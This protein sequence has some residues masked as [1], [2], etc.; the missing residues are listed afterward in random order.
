MLRLCMNAIFK[1]IWNISLNVWV[2]VGEFA[3]GKQKSK[4]TCAIPPSQHTSAVINKFSFP[5]LG[6]LAIAIIGVLG[7]QNAYAIDA[8]G[9][10]D[11]G[12]SC[13]TVSTDAELRSALT[14][15]TATTILM[16]NDIT[17]ASNIS[18]NQ[19]TSNRK[20][21]VID[22]GGFKL[23]TG[24]AQFIFTNQT[25]V[26]W[27]GAAGS[28]TLSNLAELNSATG[29]DNTVFSMDGGNSAINIIVNNIGTMTN[30]MLAVLGGM[31]SGGA[32]NLNSQLVLGNF[33]DPLSLTFGTN[34]QLAQASNIKFTGHFDLTATTG[35]Y[36]AV[37]W[38]NAA[39]ANSRMYFSSTANVSITTPLFASGPGAYGNY[40]YTLEDGAQFALNSD[41]NV[42][43]SVNG[44]LLIGTYSAGVFG[45]G[46]VLQ[47][48][49]TAGT[50]YST[51]N[52]ITNGGNINA[53]GN[54][55][56]Q[57][58]DVIYNLAAGSKLAVSGAN[59]IGILATKTGPT[60]SGG[61]YISSGAA[62]NA[63]GIGISASHGGS[64]PIVLENKNSGVITA[65]TG[66]SAT[67]TG[68]GSTDVTN[69]GVITAATGMSV[70]NTGTGTANVINDGTINST[71]AGIAIASGVGTSTVD[72][73]RGSINA[74]AGTA[75]NIAN[76][77]LLNLLG[78]NITT[79]N[80][81]TGLNFIGSSGSHTLTDL[82]FNLNGTGSAFAKAAGVNLELRHVIFNTANGTVLNDLSGLT[83]AS[84]TEGRNT[85]NVSGTGTGIAATNTALSALD[86]EALDINVSGAGVG[87]N[88]TG[89]G[90]LDFTDSNLTIT[91]T[92]TEGTALQI[93]DGSGETTIGAD[94]QID[95]TAATAINFLGSSSKTLNNKGTIKGSVI[96]AGVADHIIN[97]N[98][99]L[100]GTLTTGA[101]NDT[102]VLDSSSQ[103]NDVINLGDGNNSVTIQNGAT[104]SSIITGNGN[105]TFTINGMSVGS[106]TYLGSLDAG[107]GLNTLNFNA[108]TDELAAATSLQGFTNINLVDSHI[109]LV[110]DDN[111]GSG[112]VNID[113]SSEL[114]FGSTF[115]GI[116]HATLGTGTGSAIVNN[117]A[118]VSLEQASMFAGTWQVNQGGALTASN[119][120]QL[121]SAK[122]GVDGT[123]NLDNI[124]LFNH[125]LTGNGTLNVAKN[126]A[127]TAF[128]FGST[129]GGAFSGI[130]N[131]T[132]TTFALSADNAAALASATLKLSDD[133]VTTVGTT[134][135][136]LHGLDLSGGTL[137][138]DGAVPQSQTSGVVTV[139][140]LAL[141]SG[142]VNITG[143]GS[144]DNTD[145]L[146][147]NVS[148]LEQDR[149]GSTLE[150][151]NATNV[152][153]DIDALDLLVNGT[154]ITSGT[155]GVQSAIQQGGSTVA[156][157]IH[158][159]GLASSN[160]NGDSGLYVNY[161]LSA[162]ELLA[163]GADALLLAT[164][165]GLTANR[166]LNAELFGVGGLVVDA[167]NGALTLAN[168]SNRYE[169]TT[170]VTA[171]ELIL[172][173]N[174]AFGQTSLLNIAS[175][176]SANINGYRQTVGA[177]TNTGT[178]TLGSGGV[179]TSG[180]LTNGGGLDLT[181]GTLN[182]TAGGASTVAGGLT[183]AGT[184]NI[185][186]GNLSVSA[187]N[188]GLSG[189]THIADVASVTLTDTGTLGTSTVEVLGTL[190]LNGA[191]AA[192]TN[193]LSGGG[194]INTN[195]AVTLSGNNSFS[196]AHQI[197]TDGELTVGQASNLG[198]S[199]ATVNLGTLTSHL[200]LNG[201]SESIANVLSGVAGSTVDI[202]GGADTA[203]TANNSGFLGQY[204]LAG[205]SKL[206]VA[207]TN[208]LG[209]SSS[210][211]LA[212]AGD[213][214]SL[215]G[216]NGTF[217]NSVTGSGVLQVTDD[218]EVTLTSSNG[219][220]NAV[221]I[222]IADAT[223]N[224][225]DIALF[226]HAL[227]GNGLLNVAKNDA[228]T[229]FDFGSTVG[230]AF[231]GIVNLTNTTFALS[232]DNA[233]AL[234][235][236]TLKLS[237]DS[238]TTV[239]TTDRTLHGLDL[240]GG[241]LIFDGSPP[242]SQANGVVTVTDLALNSGTVSIT[243]VG[244]WENESPVTSPNVSIL[245]QDRAGTTLE[246]INATNV[247][248]DVDALGLMI[249]GTAITAD[250][251]GVQSAIQQGGSTVA[252]AIHNYGLASSNSNGDS[253][254]YVNYTLSALELLADG[255][256]ALLLATESGLTANRVLNAELFGV[257]G[258]VVDAQNGAL[259]L[260]N[261]SNRYEGTTTVTA[262]ELILGANG[263]F[264]QTS[265]L[266]IASGASANING[267]RQTVG[268]VT[269][270]GTVTLGSGGVLTS[271]LLTNGGGLDLTGGT[272]NLTAGGAST[273]AGGLTGAGTLNING[274]NL[275]VS[276]T[277][278]GLS[279]QTHIADVASVTL[280]DTGTLGT[281][282]VEVLGTLN[283]NGANAAMTN[284]LSGGG[285][286]NTN[287]AVTLSG[288]N[289]FS[290][291]HQIGTDGELTVG[292]ASNLGASSATVNL[293]TLT[294]HLILNGVSE[295]IANVLSGVAGS[296]VDIIGGADTALTAN[297]SGFLGQYALAGNSKLTVASTN[298]LGAS[299]SVALAGAGDT[300]SLSGFNGTFGNS[301]TG[302]GV[303]QVTDDAEVTLTSSNGVSNAVTIDIADATLNLDD[304]ALFNHALTGNGLL[305]VAKNDASTA[306]DFGSTVGG[307]FS[308]IVN[309]TNTT[310]AL[311]ADNAAALARA[312]LK[313][314]DD[315]VTTVGTT[316][317]TLHG[318]DLNGGTLIFDGS[319][320]QSQA[321]G[322]VTV[323]DLALNSGTVSITGV[324]NWENESPVTSPNVSILEQDRAGTTLELINA[325][326]VTGDVDALGLMINGTAITADSQGVQSAIQQ[327]GST[328][329]N[330]IHNYGLASSN[331][332]GD[333]GLYVNYTLSALELLAD[334]A[335]ALLLA[336][337][338][339]L[340]ANRVLNAELF[341]VGGL[342]VDA[343]NGALTLANGNNRYEGTTTVTA[344]E[345]ILGANG[346]FGQTSLLDIASGAS[347]N[348]NGYR[349]T[350]GAVTNT[351]TVTLGSGG[352]L[353][354][355]L[356]TNGGGLDLT[357]GTL[358]LTA[359]GSST[360]AGGL[361]GA[362]TLNINGGNLAVSAAN[363][364][365]SGQTHIADVASVTLTGTGT[366]GTSAV[367]VLG[368]LNLNGANA[369]MTNVLSGGG[370]INTNAAV[371][372]SG[373]NSFSGAHQIGT[374][375][376]LTVG[377]A[378]NL[379]ASSATV[380]LGTLTSH[381]ILNGVSESIANVLSGV[382][383]STVD[384]IGGADTAL[385][386]NNS[387]FL[388]QYAL[389]GNSKLTVASTN[390]L[391]ASS[392]VALAGAG[393]TLSL[394]GFNGTF[395]NSV[396]GSG[397]LQVT[398][399]AEVTLT[400]SNGVG[401]A[402]TIDIA[403][404]TLNLNDIALFDHV[405]TGNGTLNVAKNLA[406]TAF[407]FGSTVGG[408]FSGIVNLTNTTFAL[409]ADNAAALARATLKLSDDSV[410][411]V[412]TTD[413]T[414]HGL[415]L[416]GGTLIFDGSPPQS[417][418]NGVVTVTD[419]ALNSGT[420]SITGAGNWENE[421]PV[422]PPN[423]SLLEQDRGDILLQLIDA[424]NVTGNANDL[425]LVVDGTA[426]TSG[427]QGVQSA[428]QQG[429]STVANAIH[430]YG[431][432][433]S[434]SNGD[435]GLYVNYTLS[436][437]ELLADGANALL[438]A[439]ESGL[440]ANRVLNAELFGVGGLVV[441][442]QNGALT[443][444][445]GNNRYEGTTTVN[446][447]ELIL[448][449]D[450]AFGQTSLL[451]I[452]NGASANI[453]GYRQTVGAVT[454]SGAVTLGNGGELTSTDTLI[455]T[456]M[457]NVTDGIL[458]L[459][460]G[461]ASSISGGL[462]GNGIL[463]IKGG[464]FT[465]SIDNNGLAGQTNISDG[466][467]VTLGNGGTIIGTGNLGSSVIDVLG[468]LN[469][470]ADNSLANVISGDGTIN[471][472]A[473]VTL[474]GNSS[475]S[476][477]HQIGTNGELTVGQAS[478]LG[479][480]SAT[481]NLG[482]LTSHLILNGVS[483][484]IANVLSGVAGS[485]V[486][487]IGGAD[488]ALTANNSNFLGQYALAGN[489]KLTV[490]STNNLGASSSVAL[491]G[492]GDTLSLSGFNGTFG[493][494]V[495]G[496]GV[497][498]VTDD[499]EVTLT[500]SNG[501][502][503]AVT[504]DIADATLNLDDIALFNHA[505]TGNGLLNV[506]KNDASTAFDFGATVG[507][508][509]TGTVNLNNS[510]FDLSGNNTTVLAQATLKLSSGNLTS[511]G[512]GVQN[513]GTLAM[514]GGTLLFDNIVD[515]AGIIT[516]DGTIAA[517][518]INTTGGGEV[519]VNLP[520]NLAP[521]L[522]GLSV[523]ELDEGEIIVTLA[524]GAATGTGHELT[525]TDENG[526]PISAVTYQGVHNAGSTSAAATGSF[527][528]GMTTG[529][530]YDGL[531]VNYGLTALE[532][533]STGSE[534][535]VLTATLANNGTQS[536]DLSAQITGS[537]DLAFASANDGSTASLS[538]ST[539]SYTGT[540]WVSSG[541]LRLDA[542]SA[543][544]QTSL[545]AMSTATHVDING[546]QQVVGELATEG[547]STLDLNDGKLTVTGGGQ[548]DGALTGSGELVLSGGLLNV[549]YDNAG[550]TGS[551]DIANGAVAHL[552]QA[553][554]LGNGTINNNGTLHL[555]NTIGT[556]FNALTGSDGEVLLSNNASVQLAG[557]NSGYSGL[558]TNQAGSILIANSAEHLGG[559]SIA[560][561]GALILDTGSVWELT[562]TISGTG[563]L[564]KRG[565]GTVK[566]E[567]D[568]VSAGLTT[569]EEGLLQLGSSA[570][571][572]TLSLEESLQER[573]LRVSFASNMANLTSNVLITANG[574]LG[575][576]GQVTGNVE[577][578]GNLI[579]PNALT[580][581]DFGT[582]TIDGNYTG[583][584]GMI[585]FNTI[586]AGD[587]SV[588]DRLV[589]TGDTA[590]QSYVTVN[591]I[592]GVGART[593]E[594]IKIIDVGGD[595]AGQFT[596][597]GR[598]VG[599]AYEYFLYQGGAS[600]P[601]DGDWYLRTQAD[602]RRPE[603]ASYTANLAAA[604]NM[605]VTSLSDRMGET[606]YTD[607]FTGEQKTTSLWLR[608]EGSHNRSRDDS[609]EL[610]TQDNR[611]VMQLGGDV[612]QWSR[613]AQDL[614]RVGVMAGYANSSSSTVAKVAGYRSTGSV[615][616][617]SVGIYGSWL[618][619]NADDTGAYVDSWVQYSWFDNNV[620]GQDLA[621]EKYDSKGF[622]ASVE[623]GYAFKV[624]ESVNQSYFIQPKA[625]MVWMGVK[626]DDHTET[627]GTV[628]SGDGNGNIQTRLGA[629]AF[630]NPSDKAKA[631][632]PAFKPFVEA[633]WIHNTKDFG[634]TL[635]GVTVKQAGTANI[636]ELKLGVDGQ[637]NNQLN[638]WGN[639][640]QQVGNKGYSETSVVLGVKY[641]F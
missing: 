155:Q 281:S 127:T 50:A 473:T 289:S 47:L 465:I 290:G 143:S 501:V 350:V 268:A 533:L 139:T 391:G 491:A 546:T 355:G 480:S 396:T 108:S 322:V 459:E 215:S 507:G 426:I 366:L 25:N 540:T 521:S 209:A 555:D 530:D 610:H 168:G 197:G 255:A 511:V 335:D 317:R 375:G 633:N 330:A 563:T 333:S 368:T 452:A 321:N 124:A 55:V 298:N 423:V 372:L 310:F 79:T 61:I 295:S 162:L 370:V 169:G 100:D 60:N 233:A 190:N 241:T 595:S 247:T 618:A 349:Q 512:N 278:S 570:V 438:L 185:N 236:A 466:A 354:S 270:T 429:G 41:Q 1:V 393:D 15:G 615:D 160:S 158:N 151:I 568:T 286:I 154:A 265:L 608:N 482:T 253:G 149:A 523:M 545:L 606:L 486:D 219:V 528:Y 178:V 356:L 591:N 234:A 505:L 399:D 434:N 589:I 418:A 244:N 34:H 304:I 371:T 266:N 267:Y 534:A 144:W 624:G 498:Q 153:G 494:S 156:N 123:L 514:N 182:L 329:A 19:G 469:L 10:T 141:N 614:W 414:L 383:G 345:L 551:T 204:A 120:N 59:S 196:G 66:I 106:R 377:Q 229:A 529:E 404:A 492:T 11:L 601:D 77:T 275:S 90:A 635:D 479:A 553:Q 194:V 358:N 448:G 532:L 198:A 37:F 544:G 344:G 38:T 481:V 447:G 483:E 455:N 517:N 367:E 342:V 436:A 631:S 406:S 314:S 187:T 118:N 557:D 376:A 129:V 449:A 73:T 385:T 450:G 271:G 522:D 640:G 556:L 443:L 509:F 441:D 566:I 218:A 430:N 341:G 401:N 467:S 40:Q 94:T 201:V 112:M 326:N 2:A 30:S 607:V 188:S 602:D 411:T 221:T 524:T 103:S 42:F 14:S 150:L 51:G 131:L 284:V 634:T 460:N 337:E 31:G 70:T 193:V 402:V 516:S 500:S 227:T 262:G 424:A 288:N 140:D 299:S 360:V 445:N 537:G 550:F 206:T 237:D 440:T 13:V 125:V 312:T 348:I 510:T 189:Q 369:A 126:L 398:D 180:L 104:V 263:A 577:N 621:A 258:L 596:L 558:F 421:S 287:A 539:N 273:V 24:G 502:S 327:G 600:T 159:Y 177:V 316:D 297:N 107:T 384:I 81:A 427:T 565:S 388:G 130:V 254:L 214:L 451:D 87:I 137:I 478:N 109:T 167:Q 432:A 84:S 571:T 378:S 308:G 111:I 353:T 272:L 490:A 117:S 361:T 559:S 574:S 296:T 6:F 407:D 246:L 561:S 576:Y 331:S 95:A 623:G 617:Y 504:I 389:A 626:A 93:A 186:G 519:R 76:G 400:S 499:A 592:G 148:I 564:V 632:G 128:D 174:G 604:N 477:A 102:L 346:A 474:S 8:Q 357:G 311:S 457:I 52:A 69:H 588:T 362:G 503:N 92:G 175:G 256:D 56:T 365:L 578:H 569:I 382:A 12:S 328:V 72:N 249:N 437:L 625:Q 142:T 417:Q 641:N 320:P 27:G 260:A 240:N 181:G 16:L 283:L 9:C 515:N 470:V 146:A 582:F 161:T 251:Q 228:S 548:I 226:N 415:D 386:A 121:G 222:D 85:I 352:V 239:G 488:T 535:L 359:G 3:K 583:D 122:I 245:E 291:A 513:I 99:T 261:G 44:G 549:S 409:S 18:V 464:D 476:G 343:Q 413:R 593:F 324:G 463:N 213:T 616:G 62:I 611:Y 485:T 639:I 64:A 231:S 347:A 585:T 135:R 472:T 48:A 629:K 67:N 301:V 35:A 279:G 586:L 242:Q 420:V 628:I 22:G 302:S 83:F 636:A 29:N 493:N 46:A 133:S 541:N 471:T 453:N 199:S 39:D 325:T 496:S 319:P 446:L 170:T 223:L 552:S 497:L 207:S 21:L 554:G 116:L 274:G 136:T 282:T 115:D 98:G 315:S 419:L 28:F 562:N 157:A 82:I 26:S 20:D 627:N 176:A 243:G 518:S 165:S 36:P 462:T 163:D 119:S 332:N 428:I 520:S 630:I 560:N 164:E 53:M 225:D 32:P 580:G 527:N 191:N 590:G 97:N 248:G 145:P 425:D 340:T 205:N 45:S 458:N 74:S 132:K 88:A 220:S 573:A 575:G 363:S 86:A 336:T 456:G 202:I 292:Q 392:S 506:A 173:A 210:V 380:N 579:M 416:N 58:G 435:S 444:A 339:G 105:D 638:L 390:N 65:T 78:G 280:T 4:T 387:G 306:F 313:L 33:T 599:G 152:T 75:I 581:G 238:V 495:T 147:T 80:A 567:G 252:N 468:D 334:G 572:Q 307:A 439:T 461:G 54:G 250:S 269:N 489:S 166:V 89:G 212:G 63:A 323:T 184:L 531:Y 17:L 403:D 410:T 381:L 619:D 303:L 224:L 454:N 259:T 542:D 622:T 113:S 7:G 412:G 309:L 318:L 293:G 612:A 433:S 257:G 305:N 526:D 171:G 394:S 230:G 183:G 637:I 43:G 422:T 395:G 264:G 276:A 216:F 605:F 232:A 138:F 397:V 525:L 408:A 192:M 49:N 172:G 584:E 379:G 277:N 57:S 101:G 208:N 475:F 300:L 364:G 543:L 203:L 374:D 71:S 620:S 536:N 91:V 598:A 431:L 587:T 96:F 594:G 373:N 597:N 68:S 538:N 110:S 294:S 114:L 134:D 442:A 613:N 351:G 5:R 211:A 405:L 338:S 484:S 285:V 487:I 195:A 547:G 235:R 179:L 609:G 23:N 603:P 200:I 217:G 508:A